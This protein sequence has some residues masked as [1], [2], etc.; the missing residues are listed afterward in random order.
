[1]EAYCSVSIVHILRCIQSYLF[2]W[3]SCFILEIRNMHMKAFIVIHDLIPPLN[4]LQN[5]FHFS[6]AN[7]LPQKIS[8]L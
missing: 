1:M 7:F 3:Q 8:G 6:T 5:S 4:I 2:G